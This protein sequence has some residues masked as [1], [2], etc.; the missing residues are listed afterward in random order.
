M[1]RTG[2][3]FW[4]DP[5]ERA[6]LLARVRDAV[7]G[8]GSGEVAPRT[9][10][11]ESWRRSLAAH[12]DPDRGAPAHVFADGELAAVREAHPLAPVLPILRTTLLEI[13][14]EAMHVMI[15]TD[16]QGHILWREGAAGML[17]LADDLELAEG[18]RWSEDS[19][20][21]N[22]MGTSLA[23]GAAVQIHS[24]EHLVAQ[25]HR[26]TCAAAPI[27][28]P[29]SG[30]TIGAVDLTG[31]VRTF[32]PST[33]ALV[34]AA[35]RL[36]ENHLATRQAIRDERLRTRNLPHLSGLGDSPGALLSPAGRVLAATPHGWIDRRI[37]LPGSGGRVSLAEHGEGIVEPLAEGWLLRL[38]RP[39]T[40][41]V[42]RTLALPFLGAPRPVA[43]LDGRPVRLGARHAELLA[44][45]AMHPEGLSADALAVELY[46]ERGNPVTVR[47]EMHR[48]R[49]LLEAVPNGTGVV[50]PQPYRIDARVDADFLTMRDALRAGRVPDTAL[51]G[52]GELLPTSDAPGIR[53][54][55][56][57]LDVGVR[58]AVLRGGDTAAL[59]ALSRTPAGRDDLALV[60]RL[61]HLLPVSDPRHAELGPPP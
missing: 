52:R 31:A 28:D 11:S 27:R 60:E 50:K 58:A 39:S 9:V 16:A 29:D 12:V 33:L 55:R 59:W 6:A 24:S 7:L 56:D 32:H 42:P 5:V 47:A 4:G 37:D 25:Y 23:S 15:V 36:A 21:T 35:A 19:A 8:G 22:A 10:V 17:H 49:G 53:A 30:E 34:T 18:F 2:L 1:A 20:G 40:T 57:E 14:D 45:L 51:V 38:E 41:R 54:L 43:R 3:D 13:A 48:L 46:G 26:F 61:R 44:L